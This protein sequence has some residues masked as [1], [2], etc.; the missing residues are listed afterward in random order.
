MLIPDSQTELSLIYTSPLSA[1]R[2]LRTALSV[3]GE[4]VGD[5]LRCLRLHEMFFKCPTLR[6]G[7]TETARAVIG[8]L[9]KSFPQSLSPAPYLLSTLS[10]LRTNKTPHKI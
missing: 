6:R 10:T 2:R 4:A 7:E 8:P 9:T 1:V 5:P 3:A